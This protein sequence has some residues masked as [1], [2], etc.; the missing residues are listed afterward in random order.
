VAKRVLS[1]PIRQHAVIAVGQ[2]DRSVLQAVSYARSMKADIDAVFITDDDK[3]GRELRKEWDRMKIGIPLVIL[4]SP[5]RSS[6]Q[7]LVQ[8]LDLIQTRL[9][10]DCLVTVILPE[11]LPTRWWHPL[12]HN[13]FAWRLKWSLLFRPGTAVT[14]VP[15]DIHD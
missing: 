4:E 8:Y 5:Y 13:Y 14:S 2:V 15:F 9:E 3:R 10:P 12:I 1:R 7:A 6:N 11:I